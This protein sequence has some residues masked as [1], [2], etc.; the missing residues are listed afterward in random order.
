MTERSSAGLDERR[1]KLLFR[2]WRRGVREMDLIMGRFADA[3]ID[4]LDAAALDDFER[5]IEVP[6]AELYAWVVGAATAPADYDTVVLAKLRAFHG[7][8]EERSGREKG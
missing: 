3:H 5:L 6:N 8:A 4:A 7:Y 2:A 1:R